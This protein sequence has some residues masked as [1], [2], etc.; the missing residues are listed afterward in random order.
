MN[1]NDLYP[2][3]K[4]IVSL[5]KELYSFF[6]AE[7]DP[8]PDSIII[9]MDILKEFFYSSVMINSV[10]SDFYNKVGLLRNLNSNNIN[11][12]ELY[13]P[14]KDIKSFLKNN[15]IIIKSTNNQEFNYKFSQMLK[16]VSIFKFLKDTLLLNMRVVYYSMKN[17]ARFSLFFKAKYCENY[18]FGASRYVE[19]EDEKIIKYLRS[20]IDLLFIPNIL[21]KYSLFNIPRFLFYQVSFILRYKKIVKEI[22]RKLSAHFNVNLEGQFLQIYKGKNYIWNNFM[23]SIP[24]ML[25]VYDVV[26][27]FPNAKKQFLYRNGG[28]VSIYFSKKLDDLYG[29]ISIFHLIHSFPLQ[30]VSYNPTFFFGK[31]L[32][33]SKLCKIKFLNNYSQYSKNLIYVGK[34]YLEFLSSKSKIDKTSSVNNPRKN[35]LIFISNPYFSKENF[36]NLLEVISVFDTYKK[37]K[38]TYTIKLKYVDYFHLELAPKSL[39]ERVNSKEIKIISGDILT[40]MKG[41]DLIC[42]VGSPEVEYISNVFIESVIYRKPSF[43]YLCNTTK[44]RNYFDEMRSISVSNRV[45]L[46]ELLCLENFSSSLL[47]RANHLR[48]LLYTKGNIEKRVLQVMTKK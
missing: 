46:G 48:G 25:Y 23:L 36:T 9:K 8:A 27:R 33:P 19:Y 35:L 17:L 14:S 20:H 44:Y 47:S 12:I 21:H 42:V 40:A 43:L 6:C 16:E 28:N 13:K 37:D 10:H 15:K 26:R 31:Q 4:E 45:D 2:K 3:N 11:S 18:W 30:E 32:L 34:G 39:V 22:E 38:Y 24:N 7:S 29:N 41:A 5:E 1:I